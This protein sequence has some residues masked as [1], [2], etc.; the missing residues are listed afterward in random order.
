MIIKSNRYID[1]IAKHTVSL[2]IVCRKCCVYLF[3]RNEISLL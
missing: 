2:T 3:E 1:S